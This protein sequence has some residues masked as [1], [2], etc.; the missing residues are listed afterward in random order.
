MRK[1]LSFMLVLSLV[2][3]SVSMAFASSSNDVIGKECEVPVAVLSDLGIVNGYEDGSYRPDGIVT[4]AEMAVFIVNALGLEDYVTSN[5]K[6]TFKDLNGYKWA[7]GYIAYAQSLGVISGYGNGTFKPG[8]T[9]SYDEAATM[10]VAALGYTPDSLQGTWPA[11]YVTKAKALG[12]LDDIRAGSFGANRGDI[13]IMIYQTLDQ[14]IGK[15]NKDGDWV[16]YG[17]KFDRG[18]HPKEFDTMLNR[19]G[20][21]IYEPDDYVEEDDDSFVLTK[22]IA[23][24]AVVDVREYIGAVVSAYA[25]SDQEIIAI[26]EVFSIFVTGDFDKDDDVL[27]TSSQDYDF[28]S[29]AVDQLDIPYFENGDDEGTIDYTNSDKHLKLQDEHEYTMA[30]D[31]SGKKI[32]EIYSV[33]KWE[34]TGHGIVDDDDLSDIKRNHELIGVDLPEDDYDDIDE[35]A[36]ELYGV[37]FLSDIRED[38]I[39]YVYENGDKEA[40]RVAVG[41]KVV[42]GE[43]TKKSKDN[44]EIRVDGATYTYSEDEL[45]VGEVNNTKIDAGDEVKLFLDAYGYIYDAE[46]LSSGAD[47]FAVVLD[48]ENKDRNK[49]S[50]DYLLKLFLPSG[51]SKILAVDEDEVDEDLFESTGEQPW[52][53]AV[54]KGILVKYGVDKHGVITDLEGIVNLDS[55]MKIRTNAFDDVTRKGYYDGLKIA[56]DAVI[57]S[58]DTAEDKDDEDAYSV[59]EAKSLFDADD[60]AA[61][62]YII[63]DDQIV[64]MV[65]EDEYTSDEVYGVALDWATTPSDAGAEIEF[66]VDGKAITYDAEEKEARD[67]E[68]DKLYQIKF[69]ADDV[70]NRLTP[71]DD[72]NSSDDKVRK[73]VFGSLDSYIDEDD[74]KFENDTFKVNNADDLIF[75]NE[76]KHIADTMLTVDDD[77][78]AYIWDENEN[79]FSSSNVSILRRLEDEEVSRV[80]FYDVKD[81]DNIYDI[82]I[83]RKG[84]EIT[85]KDTFTYH[86]GFVSDLNSTEETIKV[87]NFDNTEDTYDYELDA[88]ELNLIQNTDWVYEFKINQDDIIKGIKLFTDKVDENADFGLGIAT[89]LIRVKDPDIEVSNFEYV[90]DQFKL[91]EEA[92]IEID[93]ADLPVIEVY[94]KDTA[95]QNVDVIDLENGI[96]VFEKEANNIIKVDSAQLQQLVT[97]KATEVRFY[98]TDNDAEFDIAVINKQ[99]L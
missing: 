1:V 68:F 10:L 57:Y 48:K 67:I 51:K 77:A 2:L 45:G 9:V 32:K 89:D 64:A 63:E 47:N 73:A 98:D 76:S 15:V 49:I 12:I 84:Y 19:L 36:F 71:F 31:L 39:V 85:P 59:L 83:L 69:D 60:V 14:A 86:M 43:V 13:A 21:E 29:A 33:M 50:S 96:F 6:S 88:D 94:K 30:V 55:D 22:G 11:N 58:Y 23:D 56:D 80:E 42:T 91:T 93:P 72:D 35:T 66:L 81:D 41:H 44:K 7:E 74:Y 61:T 90:A 37:D 34:V 5:A 82:V 28:N 26:K 87:L 4:R 99:I 25:N 62:F 52:I 8:K 97:L 79:E 46:L 16:G 40:A 53:N 38:D 27:E 65:V 95:V 17:I 3:G 70:V 78:V 18:G 54:D 20:A 24:E 92:K 75:D